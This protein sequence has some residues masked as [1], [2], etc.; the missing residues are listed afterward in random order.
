MTNYPT[1][2]KLAFCLLILIALIAASLC[3]GSKAIPL[4]VIYST[5]FSDHP[6][7][8][9]MIIL[10]GRLP[11]TLL[12]IL[13]GAAL[14]LSGALIQAIT[15]NPLAEPGILGV[16]AGAS[17]FVVLGISVFSISSPT[18]YLAI[19][20]CGAL[21]TSVMVFVVG[22]VGTQQL[23]PVRFILVGIA[24]GAVMTGLS[25]GMTLLN[26]S[27]FDKFRFWSAGSLDIRNL[28][29][30]LLALPGVIGGGLLALWLARSL[31]ALNLGEDM[32]A[33]LGAHPLR[34]Q[35][36]ALL[37]ISVLCGTA[38]A[39][40]G[41]IAF[42]GLMIPPLCRWLVGNDQRYITLCAALTGPI[43]LIGSDIIGRFLIPGELRV[44]IVTAF[45]GAPVLIWLARKPSLTGAF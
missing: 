31:N 13:A 24:L 30:A 2:I 8:D 22:R 1:G 11:R 17:F 41:P 34:T 40:A 38:T 9:S 16:N 39:V 28:N 37:A 36:L 45:V 12:G 14:G 5:L 43:L 21:L 32:A 26:P 27:A 7:P 19:A 4:E 29:L 3:L 23:D 33:T 18:S 35:M 42:V 10:Q 25:S 6:H 20:F 15:G 44:S